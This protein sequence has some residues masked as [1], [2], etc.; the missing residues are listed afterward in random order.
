MFEC[1]N[2]GDEVRVIAP[3]RSMAFIR[4]EREKKA[5][6]VWQKM[7]FNVTFGRH[8][9]TNVDMMKTA[10]IRARVE[11]LHE[12]F[13]DKNVKAIFACYGGYTANEMLDF[14]D[15]DIIKRNPKIFCGFSDF[16]VLN[17]AVYAKTG[18]ITYSGTFW[19]QFAYPNIEYMTDYFY[20]V[21]CSHKSTK[22]LPSETEGGWKVENPGIS[23]GKMIGGNLS[24]LCLLFGTEYMPSLKNSI[25]C[26]EDDTTSG[27]DDDF[28]FRRNFQA[29]TQQ[30]DFE[31]V[32]GILIGRFDKSGTN[33]EKDMTDEKIKFL[34]SLHKEIL[35]LDLPLQINILC[36]HS[37]SYISTGLSKYGYSTNV[38]F[39]NWRYSNYLC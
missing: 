14:I 26:I 4:L 16:S 9:K 24:S 36:P 7:G 12:A 8:V 35:L 19:G 21:L 38:F 29:L 5:I 22:I 37:L 27:G 31:S 11:D 30:K 33:V 39:P 32:K 34:L 13:S 6:E 10:E 23:R 15:F 28:L 1:L 20:K 25:L 17:N 18:M 2:K 3:S